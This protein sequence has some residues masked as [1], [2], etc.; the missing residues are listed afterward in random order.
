MT[1]RRNLRPPR[2]FWTRKD[3]AFLRKFYP[4]HKTADVAAILERPLAGIYSM[5]TKLG[6]KK[7]AV[8][9]ASEAS[10]RANILS[11]AGVA[12]G[13][14]KG[15]VPA[16][17][18]LRRPGYA[19]GRI[20]ET[21]FKK[22]QFPV[23]RDSDYYVLGALRVNS[24]GYIDMRVSFSPGA[25]GWRTLHRILWV[26][27]HGPIPAGHIITFKNSDKLDVCLENL[28][29]ITLA[30]NMR[31]NSIHNLPTP[32]KETIM[33]LGRLKTRIRHE[34]QDRRPA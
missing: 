34:E 19:P 18:G 20:R 23:N 2:R 9:L 6:L 4:N 29:L 1:R 26:D 28:E 15:H 10:G 8:F 33:Q 31:R 24:D 21:Q 11:A 32:L 5:A 22:G 13:F 27:A 14:P 7:S 16:N 25:H 12:H 17:K 30:D 3:L